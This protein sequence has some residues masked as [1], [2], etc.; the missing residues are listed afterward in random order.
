MMKQS[1]KPDD[2][3]KVCNMLMHER[4]IA[5]ENI[6]SHAVQKILGRGSKTTVGRYVKE[7]ARM[8]NDDKLEASTSITDIAAELSAKLSLWESQINS[9]NAETI[10]QQKEVHNVQI[11]QSNQTIAELSSEIIGLK[12]ENSNLRRANEQ[13]ASQNEELDLENRSLK[14]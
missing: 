8:K 10:V 9:R 14:M 6:T 1:F 11:Q 13:L 4:G 2:V 12:K 7:W 3:F 5:R